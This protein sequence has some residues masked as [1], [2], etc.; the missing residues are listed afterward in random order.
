M[1][2]IDQKNLIKET[3]DSINDNKPKLDIL[4]VITVGVLFLINLLNYM[5]RLVVAG[6]NIEK[7]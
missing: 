1:S 2:Q 5:D 6:I 4:N 3:K 7:F